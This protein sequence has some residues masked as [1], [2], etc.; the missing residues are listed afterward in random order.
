MPRSVNRLVTLAELVLDSPGELWDRVRVAVEARAGRFLGG[1]GEKEGELWGD[2]LAVLAGWAGT[3]VR[4]AAEEAADVAREVAGRM[5]VLRGPIA[6]GHNAD[7]TLGCACYVVAR[8]LRPEVAVE[9]GVAYGVTTAFLLSAL[10]RNG[11]GVLHSVDLPP[12]A[13]RE[14]RCVGALVP[15]RVRGRWHLHRGVS[16]RVLPRLVAGLASGVGLFV[17][18]SLHTY[19]NV[20]DE[21]KAITPKLAARSAV[22]VDDVHANRAFRE[23]AVRTNPTVWVVVQEQDKRATFGMALFG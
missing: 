13:D 15:E 1:P 14:G 8:V 18:D 2:A 5:K 21:L 3:A 23:W 4:E 12:L 19:W 17:H 9:T 6:Q 10:E 11:A 22:L 20:R 7:F 16:R